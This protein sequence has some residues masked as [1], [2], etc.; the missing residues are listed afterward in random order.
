MIEW[1]KARSDLRTLG[2]FRNGLDRVGAAINATNVPS[3][4]EERARLLRRAD[5]IE[6]L[7]GPSNTIGWKP[8]GQPPGVS[9]PVPLV[10]TYLS[11]VGDDPTDRWPA[12]LE[13]K[14]RDTLVRV[15]PRI[16]SRMRRSLILALIPL[17]WPFGIAGLILQGLGQLLVA[18]NLVPRRV[19]V[20]TIASPVGRFL[21][22]L[23]TGLELWSFWR[24]LLAGRLF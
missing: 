7:L 12:Q 21:Q 2:E 19:V 6:K 8:P 23:V 18:S 11:E 16:E 10:T 20:G 15:R 13:W 22:A 3:F 4:E 9:I 5:V 14:L 24:L 17:Y 1:L